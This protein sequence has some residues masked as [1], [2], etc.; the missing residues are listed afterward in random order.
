M[1]FCLFIQSPPGIN[2]L[3]QE[4]VWCL[5]SL[6]TIFKL[7]RGAKEEFEYTKGVIRICISKNKQ[8]NGYRKQKSTKV[9]TTNLQDI[10]LWLSCWF[11][12][13]KTLLNYLAFQNVDYKR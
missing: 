3:S 8:H 11:T 10:Q 7:Y 1:L 2:S 12:F 9:Q 4:E 13:S 5:T 6:S